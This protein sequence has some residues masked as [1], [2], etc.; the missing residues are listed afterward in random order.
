MI[1]CHCCERRLGHSL[2][3]CGCM[4]EYCNRCLLCEACCGCE[5]VP[6]RVARPDGIRPA[7]ATTLHE[8]LTLVDE[9]RGPRNT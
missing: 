8:P 1:R 9:S 4:T 2:V 5:P 3:P 6:I 7:D